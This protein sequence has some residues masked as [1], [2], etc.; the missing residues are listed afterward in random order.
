VVS[1]DSTLLKKCTYKTR[2]YP[3]PD[4]FRE[5]YDSKRADVLEHGE[6]MSERAPSSG[7]GA[8]AYPDDTD[9]GWQ[10]T[11]GRIYALFLSAIDELVKDAQVAYEWQV[12]QTKG[13]ANAKLRVGGDSDG[14]VEGADDSEGEPQ[15]EED[16]NDAEYEQGGEEGSDDDMSL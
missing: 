10:A 5:P 6:L 12:E 2:G 15:E 1:I 7:T 16:P 4:R 14:S 11:T 13:D 8:Q 3:N 9:G